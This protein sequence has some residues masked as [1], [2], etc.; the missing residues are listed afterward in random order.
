MSHFYALCKSLFICCTGPFA[1]SF[2]LQTNKLIN[3]FFIV[4]TFFL[5]FALYG[6]PGLVYAPELNLQNY[7]ALFFIFSTFYSLHYFYLIMKMEECK[8]GQQVTV[9]KTYSLFC[10]QGLYLAMFVGN[11]TANVLLLQPLI[12]YLYCNFY[13]IH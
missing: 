2:D 1:Y 5:F 8:I 4:F 13:I 11:A 7:S 10:A 9:P 6:F 3:I 12:L